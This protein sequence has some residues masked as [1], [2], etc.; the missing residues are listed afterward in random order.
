MLHASQD[1]CTFWVDHAYIALH[2]IYA[3]SW[4]KATTRQNKEYI[5]TLIQL[6][7]R[8]P[9]IYKVPKLPA[10]IN[11]QLLQINHLHGLFILTNRLYTPLFGTFVYISFLQMQIQ[12][13]LLLY[14]LEQK[15]Y[16]VFLKKKKRT[17]SWS[18]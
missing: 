10:L 1:Q 13:K 9:H 17:Y 15:I 18:R 11:Y 5:L 12:K 14:K 4:P 6:F 7:S 8:L 3:C 16:M 2:Y